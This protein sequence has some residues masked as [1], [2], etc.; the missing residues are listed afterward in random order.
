MIMPSV[1]EI[2]I[3]DVE[4]EIIFRLKKG[5]VQVRVGRWKPV[6]LLPFSP[7][8]VDCAELQLSS[9]FFMLYCIQQIN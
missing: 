6:A 8:P 5:R 3:V 4:V 7:T 2:V 9:C 1:C